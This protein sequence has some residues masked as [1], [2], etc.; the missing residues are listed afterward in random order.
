M[1]KKQKSPQKTAEEFDVLICARTG[2]TPDVTRGSICDKCCDCQ[3]AVWISL[4]GQGAMK[5]NKKL[6]PLCIQCAYKKHKG[7]KDLEVQLAPGALQEL[8]RYLAERKKH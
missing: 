3:S 6:V 8:Q 5:R 1:D 4:S 7:C 2:E